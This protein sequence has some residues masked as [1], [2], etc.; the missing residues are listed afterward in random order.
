MGKSKN[1]LAALPPGHSPVASAL[2]YQDPMAMT[3][4]QLRQAAPQMAASLSPLANMVTPAV[5]CVYGE[6]KAIREVS[7]SNGVDV[8]A[9]LVVAA[10]AIPNLLRSKIAANE[11]TAVGSCPHGEHRPGDLYDVFSGE[12]LCSQSGCTWARSP[13][14]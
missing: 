13:W 14:N 4:L 7:T 2:F 10:V 11:A 1:F 8:G 12:R 6:E 5:V 3:L 9:V